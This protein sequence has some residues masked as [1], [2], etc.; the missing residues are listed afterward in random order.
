MR[1]P[2]LPGTSFTQDMVGNLSREQF[3]KKQ[4]DAEQLRNGIRNDQRRMMDLQ[5]VTAGNVTIPGRFMINNAGEANA[6]ISFPVQFSQLP[7]LTFGFEMQNPEVI[8]KGF[9]PTFSAYII[10][11]KTI[12]RPQYS[13][14]Y[15][16]CTI[17][18]VGEGPPNT[19]YICVW[20]AVGVAFQ[21]TWGIDE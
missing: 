1:N 7:Y 18:V 9:A 8:V 5:E 19:K 15:T 4:W 14:L 13:R 11:W 21:A 2:Y 12:E 10:D 3:L 6:E 20:N 16:G 17:K